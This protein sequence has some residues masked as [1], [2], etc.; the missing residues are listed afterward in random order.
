MLTVAQ[1]HGFCF[2][3]PLPAGLGD[4]LVPSFHVVKLQVA[5][6]ELEP[7]TLQLLAVRYIPLS[8]ETM[9][10]LYHVLSGLRF[11]FLADRWVSTWL[12]AKAPPDSEIDRPDRFNRK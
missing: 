9:C 3:T 6:R 8:Y 1:I 4:A 2:W 7:Q 10:S 11:R 5:P 12:F